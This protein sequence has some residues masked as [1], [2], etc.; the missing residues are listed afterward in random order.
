MGIGY[1]GSTEARVSWARATVELELPVDA[2]AP[3]FCKFGWA[4]AVTI[5]LDSM[6]V[7]SADYPTGDNAVSGVEIGRP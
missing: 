2:D 3:A 1:L 6:E 5:D 7:I 4:A